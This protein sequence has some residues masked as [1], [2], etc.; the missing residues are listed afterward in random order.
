MPHDRTAAPVGAPLR[1]AKQAMRTRVAAARDALDAAWRDRASRA[2]CERIA[3]LPSFAS[4]RTVLLT[5]PFRSE[6]NAEP[7]IDL[8]LA[9]GK[10]VALPRV[11]E[12]ARMLELC[13]VVD[14]ARDIVVGWRGIPEPASDCSR[15]Y[16]DDVDWVLVPGV[17]FDRDG[18]RLGYGGGYYDRL[19][20]LLPARAPRVAGAFSV[21]IVDEV[22]RAPHDITMD[23]VVTEGGVVRDA[24]RSP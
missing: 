8:A 5:S 21:Q 18:A 3:A 4:A 20:P 11:V 6:W 15:V 22:P 19:L 13:R 23:V 2:L 1:E 16:A 7:L 9:Q 24:G 14:A 12:P 17:A 10:T